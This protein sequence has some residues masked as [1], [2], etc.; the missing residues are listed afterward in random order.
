MSVFTEAEQKTIDRFLLEDSPPSASA[1]KF[2]LINV[3]TNT[4]R[5]KS[6]QP[7]IR[8]RTSGDSKDELAHVIDNF[9]DDF[10]LFMVPLYEWFIVPGNDDPRIDLLMARALE[11]RIRENLEKEREYAN[12]KERCIEDIKKQNEL[13]EKGIEHAG[14]PG[15]AALEDLKPVE[16]RESD[17]LPSGGRVMRMKDFEPAT[18]KENYVVFSFL[19]TKETIE[20]TRFMIKVHGIFSNMDDARHRSEAMHKMPRHRHLETCIGVL[21]AWLTIPPPEDAE[22]IYNDTAHDDIYKDRWS[23]KQKAEIAAVYAYHEARDLEKIEDVPEEEEEPPK[24]EGS[25]SA[26]NGVSV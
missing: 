3:A 8:V 20:G 10:D 22:H 4:T 19:E 23:E 18:K 2:M 11:D 13:T 14:E 6:S 17:P 7:A 21:D 25:S 1:P 9:K 24:D 5:Q 15:K 26:D 16:K 12:R